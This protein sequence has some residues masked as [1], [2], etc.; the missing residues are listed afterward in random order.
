MTTLYLL[1]DGS[2]AVQQSERTNELARV[3]RYAHEALLANPRLT[4]GQALNVGK[5]TADVHVEPD[6]EGPILATLYKLSTQG[7]PSKVQA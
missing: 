6:E 1:A 3:L 7:F 5:R 4:F 2:P